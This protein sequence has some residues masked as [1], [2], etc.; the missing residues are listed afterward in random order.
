M[1]NR[2]TINRALR[3]IGSA[4]F[5]GQSITAPSASRGLAHLLRKS[6][7]KQI[8]YSRLLYDLKRQGL[9][10]V[11]N[12]AGR[13]RYTITPAG[14]YRLQALALDEI[15][16]LSPRT[17]DK[18][19][20]LVAFDVPVKQSR[21]RQEFVAR[22]HALNF[23]M[24]QRSLWIHPFPCFK[25]VEKIASHYNVLRHCSLMEIAQTDEA[26]A[27]KLRRHFRQII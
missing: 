19:W 4:G 17:W 3:I 12:Q 10:D 27:R 16:I 26:S 22:L 25:E 6:P 15:R 24:L 13:V 14:A 11:A 7:S 18:K 23:F 9:V 8:N 2:D 20:R 5:S 21:Q 1:A